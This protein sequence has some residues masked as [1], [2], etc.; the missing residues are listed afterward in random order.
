PPWPPTP[1][2][3]DRRG[4][5]D[6]TYGPSRVGDLE[7]EVG[8]EAGGVAGVARGTVLVD[9]HQDRVLVAVETHLLDPLAVSGSLPLDPVLLATAGPVRRPTRR[10]GAM[11][12]LVI[13]PPEH[14]HL[15]GVV[16]LGDRRHQP[17]SVALEPGGDGGVE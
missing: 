12:S 4:G 9:L 3:R 16:L 14:Q 5:W 6:R 7:Q 1:R 15:A 11:K 10:Q 13:H 8:V 17:V 2:R